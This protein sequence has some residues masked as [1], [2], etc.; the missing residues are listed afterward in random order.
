L[1]GKGQTTP[2]AASAASC[3]YWWFVNNSLTVQPALMKFL[4]LWS[5]PGIRKYKNRGLALHLLSF[6]HHGL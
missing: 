5:V 1:T 4:N 2:A 3:P 6:L